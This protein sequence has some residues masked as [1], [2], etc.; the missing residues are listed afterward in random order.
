MVFSPQR[1]S[2]AVLMQG[3]SSWPMVVPKEQESSL[4]ARNG[5]PTWPEDHFLT[6][7]CTG[8]EKWPTQG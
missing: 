5:G 8:G 1:L 6:N 3:H 2:L 7:S 4:T